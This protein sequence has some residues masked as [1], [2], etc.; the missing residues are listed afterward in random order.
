MKQYNTF[1]VTIIY[2]INKVYIYYVIL[3]TSIK[4]L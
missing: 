1:T 4:E 3:L 2:L